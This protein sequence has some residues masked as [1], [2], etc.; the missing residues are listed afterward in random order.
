MLQMLVA[1]AVWSMSRF[2]LSLVNR[3]GVMWLQV[4]VLVQAV[5]RSLARG[6][7]GTVAWLC[8]NGCW[9]MLVLAAASSHG[10]CQEYVERKPKVV[11]E[12]FLRLALRR[13]VWM[14]KTA[15][16]GLVGCAGP[17]AVMGS[18]VVCWLESRHRLLCRPWAVCLWQLLPIRPWSE[19]YDQRRYR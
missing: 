15:M 18:Y 13:A 19:C 4:L 11:S 9:V 1:E 8:R 6:L 3:G 16:V 7:D 17:A 14:R 2:V 5:S 12:D 10:I